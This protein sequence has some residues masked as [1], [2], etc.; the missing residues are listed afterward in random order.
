MKLTKHIFI[1]II[2]FTVTIYINA[3]EKPVSKSGIT[4]LS[5][6][7][8]DSL[9]NFAYKADSDSI[10]QILYNVFDSFFKDSISDTRLVF[11]NSKGK[12]MGRGFYDT[13]N[14]FL[15]NI[16]KKNNYA[17]MISDMRAVDIKNHIPSYILHKGVNGEWTSYL[18]GKTKIAIIELTNKDQD[19]HPELKITYR[20][21][22]LKQSLIDGIKLYKSLSATTP[23]DSINLKDVNLGIKFI[24]AKSI[25]SPLTIQNSI[26]NAIKDTLDIHD[27][28]WAT[29]QVGVQNTNYSL[30]NFSISNGNLNVT[31][32]STQ[33]KVWKSNLFIA[34]EVHIP[35]DIDNFKPIWNSLFRFKNSTY[36]YKNG[37]GRGFINWLRDITIDRIGIYS[38]FSLSTDPL[39]KLH[40]G[41][42]YAISKEFYL[43]FGWTWNNEVAPQI[44]NIGNITSLSDAT[45]YAKRQY[46]KPQ[47]SWGLSFS[48]S[49]VITMLGIKAK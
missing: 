28:N 17:F 5:K 4:K 21:S 32:D 43:N 44:T 10:N 35:R 20:N 12:K 13:L 24:N 16:S 30:N 33:K 41:F 47:F 18:K 26:S 6:S 49:S 7:K 23:F 34:F 37:E 14:N 48:P 19:L 11:S 27:L 29:I 2:L 25:K 39:S 8:V 9:F 36:A 38:G 15:E 31:P 42:N 1:L 45:A 40:A 46:S 22:L 3:Q